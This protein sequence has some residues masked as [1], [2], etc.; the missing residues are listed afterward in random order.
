[1][2]SPPNNSG[3]KMKIELSDS[4]TRNDKKYTLAKF[5]LVF[6]KIWTYLIFFA[7]RQI[8]IADQILNK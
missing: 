5:P 6:W 2:K 7:I 3:W 8:F 1:M 4:A